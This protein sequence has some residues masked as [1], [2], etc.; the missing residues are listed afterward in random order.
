MSFL[1]H[2]TL[3]CLILQTPLFGQEDSYEEEL[4]NQLILA[5][6][7]DVIEIPAGTHPIS[8]ELSLTVDR[9][10]LRGT[11][12]GKSILD[13][14][15]QEEGA[16]GL[17]V[18]GNGVKLEGFSII[19]TK[20]DGIKI[21]RAR[22]VTLQQIGV[23]WTQ[24]P[25]TTNGAYGLYP[26]QSE[27][28]LVEGCQVSGASDAGIYVG[29]SKR[30]LIRR[31]ETYDNVAG[32][33][34]ENSQDVQV[35]QNYSHHNTGGILVFNLPDLSIPGARTKIF[36]NTIVDNN[37]PNFAQPSNIVA[38][39]PQGTGI[40]ITANKQVEVA[41]NYIAR[42]Q[43]SG[44]LL[45][46]YLI[47]QRPISDPTY[48][49]FV[50]TIYAYANTFLANGWNPKGGSSSTTQEMVALLTQIIGVPFPDILYDG[51]FNPQR[52][53]ERREIPGDLKICLRQ[54]LRASFI[55]LDFPNELANISRDLVPHACEHPLLAD[56][57]LP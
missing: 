31:N 57:V 32:I 19:N 16:E 42:N 38:D 44:L 48:D 47:T 17:S 46:S 22:D 3:I 15:N 33:E 35:S 13:F 30:V 25:K 43:T 9:V 34:V 1:S 54:N 10:T 6:P 2:F 18:T 14:T 23:H 53:N 7:G 26:V 55:N 21:T 49:P 29:Q 24:G 4:L 20:G 8:M 5:Q 50:E 39:V 27:N 12:M 51:S 45:V 40:M 36:G 37:T 11:G 28:I 56:V 41:H 52:L